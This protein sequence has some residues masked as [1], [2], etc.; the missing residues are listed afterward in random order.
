[1]AAA[2]HNVTTTTYADAEVRGRLRQWKIALADRYRIVDRCMAGHALIADIKA[3]C[4]RGSRTGRQR[5]FTRINHALTTAGATLEGQRLD[6]KHPLAVWSILAPRD[7]VT[8]APDD[9]SDAQNCV[10]VNYVL[11]GILDQGMAHRANGLWTLDIPDHALGRLLHRSA[12]DPAASIAAAHHAALRLRYEDVIRGGKI[13]PDF[14]FLL[15]AGPGAFVCSLLIGPD[16]SIDGQQLL[17]LR[18]H[19]WLAD[20]ML[21]DNQTSLIDDGAAGH[22]LGDSWLL[23]APLRRTVLEPGGKVRVILR[24]APGLLD[25]PA[26]PRTQRLMPSWDKT[27]R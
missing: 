13:D 19:T 23:P 3:L 6:G 8:V 22:R 4:A 18:V 21:R 9:P 7:S 5:A 12:S 2:H 24:W 10:T 17:R 26:T 25:T 1:M 11:I 14:Q 15:P 16:I 27:P 20:D